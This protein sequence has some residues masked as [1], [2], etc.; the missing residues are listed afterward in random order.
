MASALTVDSTND[1]PIASYDDLLEGV[2]R[3]HQALQDRGSGVAPRMEKA[4]GVFAEDG[5]TGS[6]TKGAEPGSANVLA[7]LDELDEE[8]AGCPRPRARAGR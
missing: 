6:L 3:G 1:K 2:P 7:L 5:S 8:R 4:P